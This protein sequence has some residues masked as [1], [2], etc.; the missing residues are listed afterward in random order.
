M[1]HDRLCIVVEGFQR[2]FVIQLYPF[3][4]KEKSD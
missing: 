3:E 4:E 1:E 2:V